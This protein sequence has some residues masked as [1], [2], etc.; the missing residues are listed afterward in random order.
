M[1]QHLTSIWSHRYFWSSLVV[2]D[3]RKRYRRTTFGIGWSVLQPLMMTVVFCVVF[4]AWFHNQNWR[5][6]APYFLAGTAIFG[7][8]R[9]SV[10]AGCQTFFGNEHYIRQHPLPLTVYTLR[11]V[12]GEGIHY[13]IG[14]CLMIVAVFALLAGKRLA[15]LE[16]IWVLVPSLLLLFLFCWSISIIASFLSVYFHDISQLSDVIFQVMFFLTPIVL[17]VENFTGR[18]SL[19]L[20]LN[21]VVPFLQI[22]RTP[23]LEG[24]VPSAWAFEKAAL[25]VMVS[26][27]MAMAMTASLQKK[28]IFRL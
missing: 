9:S 26:V 27:G 17:P 15:V 22:I 5:Q 20:T 14:Q 24:K 1:L 16:T 10:T 23:L 4:G 25:I 13:L 28:L 11:T 3:L 12:L 8:I 7:F 2:M 21:P 6:Y 18:L 19:L